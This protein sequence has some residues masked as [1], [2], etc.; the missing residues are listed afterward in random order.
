VNGAP[1]PASPEH[2]PDPPS[3]CIS[4]CRMEPGSGLCTGCWRTLD[5]IAQWGGA[6]AAWKRAVWAQI[7]QR[8]SADQA[9]PQT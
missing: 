6:S 5:E 8:R 7:R 3:P 2:S 1:P 4:V 9:P